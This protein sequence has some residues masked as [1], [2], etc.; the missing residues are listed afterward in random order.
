MTTQQHTDT[1]DET[2]EL[3][4]MADTFGWTIGWWDEGASPVFV[5]ESGAVMICR[6]LHPEFDSQ[7]NPAGDWIDN[8][9]GQRCFPS[10]DS[11]YRLIDSETG[12][13]IDLASVE[14]WWASEMASPEGHILVD[15]NGFGSVVKSGR[16]AEG[17]VRKCYVEAE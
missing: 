2:F 1:Y 10:R 15:R 12:E 17:V 4:D 3:D 6:N 7:G 14:Q 9:T 11:G 16:Y 8:V 13:F 5:A